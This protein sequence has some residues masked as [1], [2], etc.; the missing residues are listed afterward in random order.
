MDAEGSVFVQHV[1]HLEAVL[2]ADGVVVPVVGRSHFEAAGSE[3]RGHVVV[4]DNGHFASANRNPNVHTVQRRVAHVFGVDGYGHVTHDGLRARGGD[5]Q[6]GSG[7][8]N[9]LVLHVVQG[10]GDVLVND[11][12]VRKRGLGLGIPVHHAESAVDVALGV[13]IGKHVVHAV[14]AHLIHGEGVAVPVAAGAELFELVEDD[15]AVLVR[16]FPGVLQKGVAAEVRLF[17]TLGAELL[18]HLGLCRD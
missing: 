11:L 15:S 14:A 8:L 16:P 7:L 1:E 5:G 10:G 4:E 3:I 2:L 6:K 17:N 12:F 9:H 13:Q 18:H